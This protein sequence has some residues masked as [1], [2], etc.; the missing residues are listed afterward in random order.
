MRVFFCL[1][2]FVSSLGIAPKA[3]AQTL[4]RPVIDGANSSIEVDRSLYFYIAGGSVLTLGLA[5]TG[6]GVYN[7]LSQRNVLLD[8]SANRTQK[9]RALNIIPISYGVMVVGG[10]LIVGGFGLLLFGNV[11]SE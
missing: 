6:L 9:D 11:E 7:A 1:I 2:L 10:V 3:V 4:D 5:S 8:S